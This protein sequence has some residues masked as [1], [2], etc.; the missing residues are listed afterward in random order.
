MHASFGE[1]DVVTR[2]QRLFR[3]ASGSSNDVWRD[4]TFIS[5]RRAKLLYQVGSDDERKDGRKTSTRS[6]FGT[7]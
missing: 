6:S 5:K 7:W 3:A 4:Q 2:T 1:K